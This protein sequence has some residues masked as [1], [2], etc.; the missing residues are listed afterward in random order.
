MARA[1]YR[2]A[3]LPR[4]C[5]PVGDDAIHHLEGNPGECHIFQC[6]HQTAIDGSRAIV[7]GRFDVIQQLV[8]FLYRIEQRADIVGG[9]PE[10]QFPNVFQRDQGGVRSGQGRQ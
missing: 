10:K 9:D 1:T 2:D 7:Q 8:R 6:R 5:I 4:Q 3:M